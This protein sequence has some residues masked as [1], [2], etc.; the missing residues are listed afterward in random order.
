[1]KKAPWT[2]WRIAGVLLLCPLY[3]LYGAWV[4]LR[5]VTGLGRMIRGFQ[6]SQTSTIRCPNGH[7]NSTR[8]RF[9]CASCRATYHGWVGACGLCG[10]GA[11]WV[12]CTICGV[13]IPLPWERR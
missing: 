9:E 4:V 1:M 13:S 10:V 5:A 8:G 12:P 3:V 11:A 7:P 2:T 6:L